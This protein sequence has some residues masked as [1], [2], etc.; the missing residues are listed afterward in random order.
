MYM[1]SFVL[2]SCYD[3]PSILLL[4]LFS[5]GWICYCH[6]LIL[7][8]AHQ[9]LGWPHCNSIYVVLRFNNDSNVVCPYVMVIAG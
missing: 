3:T 2:G 7:Q 5:M 9:L 4:Q 6:K 8:N 1:Y